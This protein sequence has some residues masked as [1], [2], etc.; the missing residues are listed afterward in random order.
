RAALL[1]AGFVGLNE[2]GRSPTERPPSVQL[3][4]KVLL[5]L[6]CW[7]DRDACFSQNVFVQTDLDWVGAQ[8]T[9]VASADDGTTIDVALPGFFDCFSDRS[10]GDRTEET[11]VVTGLHLNLDWFLSKLCGLSLCSFQGAS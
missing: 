10:G 5:L 9:D 6:W 8:C 2:T 1:V 11:A 4:R 7:K 3:R